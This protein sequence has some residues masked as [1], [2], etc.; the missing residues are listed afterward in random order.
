VRLF[1]DVDPSR[2]ISFGERVFPRYLKAHHALAAGD[3]PGA[4]ALLA[5]MTGAA[6]SAWHRQ[7]VQEIDA[8]TSLCAGDLAR[9]R[10]LA[11]A[12]QPSGLLRATLGVVLGSAPGA[13]DVLAE[14]LEET[15]SLLLLTRALV[16]AGKADAVP[17][18]LDRPGMV[19]R[20]PDPTLLGA[21]EALFRA[22]AY[23]ACEEACLLSLR[24]YGTPTHLYNA[25]C[26]ASRVGNVDGALAYLRRARDAGF[27]DR[28]SLEK[29]PDLAAVRAD[30][31]F[32]DLWR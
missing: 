1:F 30:A 4:R 24:A 15:P 17:R 28:A 26:C 32:A 3:L 9:V 20:F 23:A 11:A 10:S 21:T 12:A 27:A 22:G 6:R 29:D 31:R 2:I 16:G 5:E 18:L 13:V 19:T 25:A 14:A 8:W 7:L